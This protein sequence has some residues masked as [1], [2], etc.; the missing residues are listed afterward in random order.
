MITLR[1]EKKW[2]LAFAVG[3]ML[4]TTIPYLAGFQIAQANPG[5]YY[6][7]LLFGAEDGYSYLAKM[8]WG[9]SGA[10]IFRS[11]YTAYP[12]HG[13]VAFLPYMLLGKLT[14]PPGQY[15]QL[16]A[17]FHLFRTAA[18]ILLVLAVYDFIAFFVRAESLRRLG[19]AL[20]V[21]GGGL[22]W[23]AVIGLGS[24]W[25]GAL[26]GMDMPLEF[27][28]PETFGFLMIFGL[29]HLAA[30]RAL[31]LWSLL[32]Y[33]KPGEGPS[34]W[35]DGLLPGLLCLAIG[36]M[37]PLTVVVEWAILS[38][39]LA[40]V[41]LWQARA[42][43]RAYSQEPG[44]GWTARQAAAAWWAFARRAA[45]IVAISSP[46]VV[47]T[48]LAF[49]LDP[50]LSGWEGQNRI[51]SPPVHH[52]LLAFGLLLPLVV[53]GIR[54]ALRANPWK[55]WFLVAW[56]AIFPCLAYAPYNLQRRLPEAI[57][58]AL[59]TLALVGVESLQGRARRWIPRPE[60]LFRALGISFLPTLILFLGSLVGIT[61]LQ[62]P[63]Y[64]ASQEVKVFAYLGEHV[65]QEDLRD[66]VVLAAFE[67]SNA[68]P[69]WAPVRTLL[70]S[71][72]ESV[73]LKPIEARVQC[74]YSLDC[75]DE[76]RLRLLREF[77]ITFV[78]WGPL[79]R[80]LG[81][82]DPRDFPALDVAYQQGEVL[83]LK[84]KR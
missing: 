79:E 4:V 15:E 21:L 43:F 48:F 83:L 47:Y 29:P 39:H 65:A 12:T 78:I 30:A 63:L 20:A 70:G 52:Y 19:L 40:A 23:L 26:P 77:R 3:V 50:V 1:S 81:S 82:W 80:E 84:V 34:S 56:A 60:F 55:G 49:R 11:P 45:V 69:A 58:V 18:G 41:A 32:Q 57:W 54:P 71:G 44:F 46:A 59:V 37:Q 14:A 73:N 53:V 67:T 7:G 66:A 35:R 10:W 22:G 8:L 5:W 25:S 36:I 31:L 75:T 68:L 24:L 17:L 51:I 42:V 74:F 16:V 6:S 28:S 27:Y 9:A 76:A 64:R 62:P 33:L 61:T 13:M 72:P 38:A 2:V